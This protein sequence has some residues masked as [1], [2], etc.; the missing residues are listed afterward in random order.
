MKYSATGPKERAGKKDNN[1][2]IRMTAN[3]IVANVAVSV[4][5]VP[6]PSG[7][8]FFSAKSPAMATEPIIGRKRDNINTIP[9]L[10]FHHRV[11]SPNPSNPLPL[12]AEDEVYS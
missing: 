4:L 5:N 2:I 11:L 8:N 1:A 10:I 7:I 3:T 12:F 9:V 6:S